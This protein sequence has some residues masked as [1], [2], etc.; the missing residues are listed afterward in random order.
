MF[1]PLK[2]LSFDYKKKEVITY[3]PMPLSSTFQVFL[4]I[5]YWTKNKNLFVYC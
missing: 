2:I 3:P 1:K 4:L 5:L